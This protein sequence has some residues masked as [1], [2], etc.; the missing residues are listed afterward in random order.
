MRTITPYVLSLS[1]VLTVFTAGKAY[2]N[3]WPPLDTAALQEA[4]QRPERN[5]ADRIRDPYRKPVDVI[6]FLE[7]KPGMTVLDIYA[8]SGYFSYVLSHATGAD[9]QVYAQNP[10]HTEPTQ[11]DHGE[12][13]EGDAIFARIATEKLNNVISLERPI[14]DLGLA[15]NSVDMVLISQV[16]HD[17]F[18]GGPTRA[19]TMLQQ[20]KAVLKPDGIVG[21]IDHVGLEDQNNNRMHRITLA[22]AIKVIED[23]GFI[24]EAQ[25]DLLSN[26]QD[27]HNRSI[28]D[29]MLN[30]ATDQFL[31][32]LRKLAD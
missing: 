6:E 16:L 4:L 20:V 21:I 28:F 24:V 18:N 11:D 1:V 23:A 13:T 7:I 12:M 3:D 14:T 15:E 17:Y 8:G 27:R 2:A 19:R 9:G 31:L 30:R 10:P 29:P 26:P 25:S 5:V 22:D 32:R